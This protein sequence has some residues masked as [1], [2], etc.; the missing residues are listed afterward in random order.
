MKI[1]ALAALFAVIMLSPVFA[2]GN[3]TVTGRDLM[4]INNWTN[5]NT[6]VVMLNLS[7]NVTTETGSRTVNVTLLNISLGNGTNVGNI[8]AVELYLNNVSS[9]GTVIGS[10]VTPMNSTA[11]NV[12]IPNKLVV[13]SS[14]NASIIVRFNLTF[15]ATSHQ[16]LSAV[17]SSATDVGVDS[18]GS[19]V[20]LGNTVI[21]NITI[22]QN[23]HANVSI[24][25]QFLDT[26][27]INQSIMY[28]IIPTGTDGV[29][30]TVIWIPSGY[31]LTNVSTVQVDGSNTTG[32]VTVTTAPNYINVTVGG[33]PTIQTIKVTF[34]VNTSITRVNS[35]AF[36]SF[37]HGGNLTNISTD[38]PTVGSTNVTTQQIVNV[39]GIIVNK[40][41]A[42]VNG[43]DY[44]E[45]NITLNFTA[46]LT[47]LIQ[48]KMTNWTDASNP[49]NTIHL[50]TSSAFYATLRNN[51]NNIS[52]ANGKINV[53]NIYVNNAGI[54]QTIT[55]SSQLTVILRMILPAGTAISNTWAATY[56]FL[57]RATP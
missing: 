49:P 17:L 52:D 25:P 47:G 30:R 22:I 26:N 4:P 57:F 9:D 19:N 24:S 23:L 16:F 32:S 53:T 20:T 54:N 6:S 37:L 7:L 3:L 48:F 41:A 14:L 46:N 44:W 28:T 29:N 51:T 8:S 21:S 43:T 18:G 55:D 2:V 38:S 50:N 39:T 40:G 31:N 45:F 42:I 35:A 5:S 27:T 34:N 13:N 10:S 36:L 11:F 56:N 15:N 33:T 1:F 12:T